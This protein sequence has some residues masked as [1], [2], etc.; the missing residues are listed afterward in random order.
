MSNDHNHTDRVDTRHVDLSATTPAEDARTVLLNKVN[1]GAIFAGAVVALVIQFLLTLLGVGIGAATLD[2][3]TG[4][5]P[6]AGTF[7]TVS[8]IWYALA[9]IV[10][11]FVGGFIASRMSGRTLASSGSL[12]GLTSWAVTTLFLL[13]LLTT[14]VGTLVG[15]ALNGLGAVAGGLGNTV[16]TAA[17]TAAPA[18]ADATDPFAAIQ[19][20]ISQATGGTDP[21]ALQNAAVSAVRAAV[22]GDPAQ[23][24]QA[25]ETA[26]QALARSQN[27]PI[28]Q[29]RTQVQGYQQ[30]YQETLQTVQEQA[31]A[32][33]DAAA[34]ATSTGA[35]AAFF[36]LLL[37]AVAAWFGGRAGIAAPIVTASSHTVVGRH[38]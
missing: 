21:Q 35:I 33:A 2:P 24:Q 29:A 9:G 13:Y 3:S 38:A 5:N 11:A 16:A 23:A 1:W 25:S 26:A 18:L 14:A 15:G 19:D 4:D 17:E 36:A 6:D 28:E 37:G 31:T 12:H 34:S 8:A 32:A 7:S 10:A 27:I 20:Q 22:T 30:Q